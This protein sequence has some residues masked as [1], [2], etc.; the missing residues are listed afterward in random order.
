MKTYSVSQ[1]VAYSAT[2][3]QKR[4]V[5]VR[6]EKALIKESILNEI[7]ARYDTANGNG[8]LDQYYDKNETELKEKKTGK[9]LVYTKGFRASDNKKRANLKVHPILILR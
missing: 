6:D 5:V 2:I 9:T 7:W 3:K 4:C 8:I 1:W